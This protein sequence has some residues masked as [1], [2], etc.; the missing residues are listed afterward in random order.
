MQSLRKKMG[1]M[2]QVSLI[3]LME[4]GMIA[5]NGASL[6]PQTGRFGTRIMTAF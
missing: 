2:F 6:G 4:P 5:L 1:M 3:A